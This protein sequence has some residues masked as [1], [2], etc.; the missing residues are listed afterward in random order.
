[1]SDHAPHL[2]VQQAVT[3][4]LWL[5]IVPE[6]APETARKLALPC[7]HNPRSVSTIISQMRTYMNRNISLFNLLV[8]ME[9]HALQRFHLHAISATLHHAN[10]GQI[11][12]VP[13]LFFP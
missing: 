8:G 13:I 4:N 7:A 2:T 10:E 11:K 3:T 9:M 6:M 5:P 1:M 12:Y